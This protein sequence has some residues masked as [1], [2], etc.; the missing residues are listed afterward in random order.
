M[1]QTNPPQTNG[2]SVLA[3]GEGCEQM[4]QPRC[5]SYTQGRW[6][7]VCALQHPLR[8][9]TPP[10]EALR[11]RLNTDKDSFCGTELI[12]LLQASKQQGHGFH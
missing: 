1:K 10:S 4:K 2:T 11:V 9:G 7:A 12:S 3:L 5:F 6:G 8:E